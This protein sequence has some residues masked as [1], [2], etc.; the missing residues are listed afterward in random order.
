MQVILG[1][2]TAGMAHAFDQALGYRA[3]IETLPAMFG[4]RLQGGSQIRLTQ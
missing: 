1:P 2:D 3:V 4:Q